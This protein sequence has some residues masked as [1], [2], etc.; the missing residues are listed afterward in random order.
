[1]NH[2][3]RSRNLWHSLASKD[4]SVKRACPFCDLA[5]TEEILEQ[6]PTMRVLHNRV[7]YDSFEGIP[8]KNHYM[9]VPIAHKSKI[10][11]FTGREKA[12]YL[13][14]VAKYEAQGFSFYSRGLSN[15][16]RSQPHLHTHLL[17][18]QG[19]RARF[20]LYIRRP[21]IVLRGRQATSRG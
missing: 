13:E 14:L 11:E 7:K 18:L 6:T 20:L 9:I 15:S 10:S 5:P 17:H 3:R 16:E 12:E 19:R 1:M 8:A 21:Y 4:S 2:D